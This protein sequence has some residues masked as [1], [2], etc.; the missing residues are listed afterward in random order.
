[1]AKTA[2]AET[3]DKSG[4]FA[5]GTFRI[6]R[7]VTLLDLREPPKVPSLFD[8]NHAPDRRWAR[9]MRDFVDDFQRPIARDDRAHIEYVPTQ[10]VTEYF[11]TVVHVEGKR[12]DGILYSSTKQS[13]GVAVVLF[14]DTF[15]VKEDGPEDDFKKVRLA[16]E[17]EDHEQPWLEMVTCETVSW[18]AP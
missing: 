4:D 12:L 8:I 16:F 5:V 2:L 3:A 6:L 11:R 15:D 18:R 13:R 1:M 10:V 14:A 7:V 17:R 9:F